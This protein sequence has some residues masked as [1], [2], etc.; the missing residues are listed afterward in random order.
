LWRL[1]DAKTKLF[2]LCFSSFFLFFTFKK[3]ING[4][5][6]SQAQF[7]KNSDLSK[8]MT[9]KNGVASDPGVR[10]LL[11]LKNKYDLTS[12]NHFQSLGYLIPFM[13]GIIK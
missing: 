11:I 5:L 9:L 12:L 7:E 10:I 6:E 1:A 3:E 8:Y 2:I 4:S 13:I